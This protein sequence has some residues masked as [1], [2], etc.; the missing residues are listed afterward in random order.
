MCC[1]FRDLT[2]FQEE[3]DFYVKKIKN[4]DTLTLKS[5]LGN[6]VGII[7]VATE[8]KPYLACKVAAG[9]NKKGLRIKGKKM[10]KCNFH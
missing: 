2:V 3:T 4:W 8:M 7:L 5:G 10:L 6:Q 1:L 9:I